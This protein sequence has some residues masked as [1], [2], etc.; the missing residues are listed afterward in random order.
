MFNDHYVKHFKIFSEETAAMGGMDYY[1]SYEGNRPYST[2]ALAPFTYT[3]YEVIKT[4]ADVDDNFLQGPAF[5]KF[6]EQFLSENSVVSRVSEHSPHRT[7]AHPIKCKRVSSVQA[8][9]QER[10]TGN[11][12]QQ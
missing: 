1:E 9:L 3:T 4:D 12:K 10:C 2:A 7:N 8:T 11:Q 6:D 5:P